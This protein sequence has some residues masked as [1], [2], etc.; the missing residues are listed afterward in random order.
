[1]NAFM[2]LQHKAELEMDLENDIQ[3]E[4][5]EAAEDEAR[6]MA[7]PFKDWL[8]DT[9]D[10]SGGALMDCAAAVFCRGYPLDTDAWID[11]IND[12]HT[13][14]LEDYVQSRCADADFRRACAER[15]AA[16]VAEEYEEA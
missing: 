9:L 12:T 6:S 3:A 1:M 15:V 5:E 11:G 10:W 16:R 14:L 13:R 8:H 2:S 4:M 7:R